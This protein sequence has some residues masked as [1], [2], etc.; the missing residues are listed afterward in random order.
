MSQS[1]RLPQ[2][3]SRASL[4]A[5]VRGMVAVCRPIFKV[6]EGIY[7]NLYIFIAQKEDF[8]LGMEKLEIIH[9]IL[10]HLSLRPRV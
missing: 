5:A 9:V 7:L 10:T 8:R 6:S 1:E 3:A 2:M 4:W